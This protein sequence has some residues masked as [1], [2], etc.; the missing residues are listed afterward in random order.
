[1][2]EVTAAQ[3]AALT[4]FSERTIRRKIASGELHAQRIAA[5]RYAIKVGDLPTHPRGADLAHRLEAL[6]QRVRLLEQIVTHALAATPLKEGPH[7]AEAS[8]ER[9][10]AAIEEL[11]ARLAR[12]TERLAPLLAP[13]A[14]DQSQLHVVEQ[15]GKKST[16]GSA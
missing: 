4:G 13:L 15:Q 1:M 14:H 3:A 12:E 10:L 16:E 6:E 11:L 9:S 8:G 5:N 2:D 7:G